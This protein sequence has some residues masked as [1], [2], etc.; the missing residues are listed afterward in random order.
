MTLVKEKRIANLESRISEL[1]EMVGNY[2]KT[3]Q[4]DLITIQK[5]KVGIFILLS[6]LSGPG[7]RKASIAATQSLST[8]K[9]SQS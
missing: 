8:K 6:K 5:L 9:G 3:R 7:Y 2:D 1:S 4:Q